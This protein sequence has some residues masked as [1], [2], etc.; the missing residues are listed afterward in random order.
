VQA[1]KREGEDS[2]LLANCKEKHEEEVGQPKEK[3]QD[4]AGTVTRLS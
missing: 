2:L 1:S 3:L 4:A